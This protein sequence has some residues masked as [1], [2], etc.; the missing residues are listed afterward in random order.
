MTLQQ[1][2]MLTP[3]VPASMLRQAMTLALSVETPRTPGAYARFYCRVLRELGVKLSGDC[4]AAL[5][6]TASVD[7]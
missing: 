1:F 5:R 2:R 4:G 6:R 7:A 3:K